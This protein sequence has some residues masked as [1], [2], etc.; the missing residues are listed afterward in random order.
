MEFSHFLSSYLPDT[1]KPGKQLFDEMVEQAQHAERLGYCGVT[2]P[3]HHFMNILLNPAP[4]QMAV[5]LAAV[6]KNIE[7]TTAVLAL[8]FHDM[9]R[10]SGEIAVADIFCEGRLVLG[11]G[12]GAFGYEFKRF[13]VTLEES[14][15]K[16]DE[17]MD[18]LIKLLT[19]K[20][21]AYEGK[22]YQ[23]EPV[24]IMPRS[25]TQPMPPIMIAALAPEA[26]Y[27]SAKRGFD[28]QTTPLQGDMG[29]MVQQ[30]EAFH[31][32]AEESNSDR[33]QKISLLRVGYCANDGVDAKAKQKGAYGYYQRFD[34]VLFS[35]PGLITNG[36]IDLL[37]KKESLEE[38]AENL[39][40]GTAQ[41]MIDKLQIYH[42]AGID[43]INL[44][45]NI[46]ANQAETLEAMQ[47]FSEEVAPHFK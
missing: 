41:E 28:I 24:T 38:L 18:V 8:P 45:F 39:L 33:K 21:V 10:L 31:R 20:E 7:I 23:F 43:E 22:Y 46:G 25:T 37:P 35:G 9:L 47:R 19:E 6:T 17:S 11:V 14:R 27:H 34:N 16:F 15:E 13:G 42:E 36:A 44:N 5:K 1:R 12:R 30:V 40:V 2:I 3:E 4:L 26:I 29:H 32:G